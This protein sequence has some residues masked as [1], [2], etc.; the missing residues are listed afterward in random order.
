M[1]CTSIGNHQTIAENFLLARHRKNTHQVNRQID[2]QTFLWFSM[3]S[4][5]KI[6]FIEWSTSSL[7]RFA[8]ESTLVPKDIN[9]FFRLVTFI[10]Q[11]TSWFLSGMGGGTIKA[12]SHFYTIQS[13]KNKRIYFKQGKTFKHEIYI[14]FYVL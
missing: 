1:Q 2:L 7:Q 14:L 12:M 6:E 8:E 3:Y 10:C 4:I 9:G 5:R 11:Q 13:L